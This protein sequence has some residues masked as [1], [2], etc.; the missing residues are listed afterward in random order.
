MS[1]FVFYKVLGK[2]GT[3]ES[4]TKPRW[5]R[6]ALLWH[7][8]STASLWRP[9]CDALAKIASRMLTGRVRTR[10]IPGGGGRGDFGHENFKLSIGRGEKGIRLVISVLEGSC[11][12]LRTLN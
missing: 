9:T 7:T 6:Q 10:R 3:I 2:V 11:M 5:F 8:T 1:M 12:W 4:P